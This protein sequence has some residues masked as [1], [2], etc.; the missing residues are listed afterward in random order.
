MADYSIWVLE[1][2]S[3]PKTETGSIVYGAYNQGFRA[4]PYAYVVLQSKDHVA[5]VDV[6][7]N[8]SD[9]GETLAVRYGV[10]HW[11]GPRE[12][13]A[14]CGLRPE[15]VD[16]VFITHAHFDHFGNVEAFPNAHFYI[17]E[18]EIEKSIWAL[19]LPERLQ[20]IASAIDP[21]DLARGAVLAR[22]GRLTLVTS[23]M[24]NVLPGID[25]HLAPD[26][27]SFASLWVELR[28]DRKQ[29]SE[30][31]WV[32]AG[33]LVYAYENLGGT[34]ATAG[35][36]EPYLPIGF[37]IGSQ[38]NLLLATEAMLQ[39]VGHER[40]R[41]V[42]VHED[43]LK[44]VFPSRVKAPGLAISEICLADGVSSRLS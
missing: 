16:T 2:A 10:E 8:H 39:A 14:L 33:D 43:R 37:A 36:G 21:G 44:Q 22:Q 6:G 20:V 11:H 7:H 27:H 18:Q 31:V 35:N 26:T 17:A 3:Q 29:P 42:P 15:D 13:L 28:N 5:M 25:L 38:T 41:V 34:G 4:M 23:D 32:L 30:D 9:F 40:R 24:A 1:Y 19:A 12:A